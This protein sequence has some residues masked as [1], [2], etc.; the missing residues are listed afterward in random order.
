LNR[1]RTHKL[2]RAGNL[3]VARASVTGPNGNVL[4][5]RL[6]VD[7]GASC[8][9]IPIE[10]AKRI[11]CDIHRPT[12]TVR[13]VAANGI[14]ISPVLKLARLNCFGF[15]LIG[16]PVVAHTL[17]SETYVDGLLGMDFLSR[18]GAI[19][20]VKRGTIRVGM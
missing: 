14:I 20:D 16:F 12:D 17:P 6:L 18:V 9:I 8:T 19:L 2:D 7:T 13:I 3:L 4:V 10:A 5:L 15:D 1:S 11:G